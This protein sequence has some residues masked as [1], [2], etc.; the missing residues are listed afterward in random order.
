MCGMRKAAKELSHT[1][2]SGDT[3]R[4]YPTWDREQVMNFN[5]TAQID[6]T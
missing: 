1:G 6:A 5:C 2:D 4:I 3:L